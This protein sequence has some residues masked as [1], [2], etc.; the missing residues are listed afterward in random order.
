MAELAALSIAANVA[1]FAVYGLQ[2]AHF[3]YNAYQQTDDFRQARARMEDLARNMQTSLTSIHAATDV[4]VEPEL[5]KSL[6]QAEEL[7][8]T[9]RTKFDDLDKCLAKGGWRGRLQLAVQ[10]LWSKSDLAQLSQRLISLRDELGY[11]LIV[12]SQYVA[13]FICLHRGALLTSCIIAS[14][15]ALPLIQSMSSNRWLIQT[16]QKC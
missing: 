4:K 3:L 8:Q 14:L 2:S 5:E 11:Q 7:A 13:I 12:L 1:Q 16:T 9:L 10:S 15:S 6:K